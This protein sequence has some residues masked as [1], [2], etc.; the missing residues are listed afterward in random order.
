MKNHLLERGDNVRSF[1]RHVVVGLAHNVVVILAQNVDFAANI[2]SVVGKA[3][4]LP[5]QFD[6]ETL[7]LVLGNEADP[8]SVEKTFDFLHEQEQL[9][10]VTNKKP[11]IVLTETGKQVLAAGTP[12]KHWA[13]ALKARKRL[14]IHVL[15]V[16]PHTQ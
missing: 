15:K 4:D 3:T 6:L 9:L 12:F 11:Q 13:Q 5:V 14:N 16:I 7:E 10:V 8:E 1:A 2:L